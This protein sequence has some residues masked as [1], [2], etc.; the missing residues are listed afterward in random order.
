MPDSDRE[1]ESLKEIKLSLATSILVLHVQLMGMGEPSTPGHQRWSTDSPISPRG[2]RLARPGEP[3]M[4]NLVV[5]VYAMTTRSGR[6]SVKF[7]GGHPMRRFSPR[8]GHHVS[9]MRCSICQ[10]EDARS[11]MGIVPR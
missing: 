8:N 7:A 5:A 1:I 6:C 3:L 2:R 9:S 10:P 11:Q 4:P